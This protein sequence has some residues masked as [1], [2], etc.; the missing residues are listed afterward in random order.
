MRF[1]CLL[2][3]V[4]KLS[5]ST[6]ESLCR[7]VSLDAYSAM[8]PWA[9]NRGCLGVTSTSD[10]PNGYC[11]LAKPMGNKGCQGIG[12]STTR[13]GPNPDTHSLPRS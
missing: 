3:V 12:L 2:L 10:Y 11:R 4:A 9:P 5:G 6:Y 8:A 13:P 7:Q 1:V